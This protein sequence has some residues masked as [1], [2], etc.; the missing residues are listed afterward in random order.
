MEH[1][2]KRREAIEHDLFFFKLV[3]ER[4]DRLR[5]A[6]VKGLWSALR[7]G[8]EGLWRRN[9]VG[10]L[11]AIYG[12]DVEFNPRAWTPLLSWSFDGNRLS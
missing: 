10:S 4:I 3:I 5:Y 7:R 1:S 9:G 2:R 6:I 11:A 12:G 8:H